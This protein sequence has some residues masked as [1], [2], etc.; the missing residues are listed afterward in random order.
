MI[1]L[2]VVVGALFDAYAGL[3]RGI[4]R[5]KRA[6]GYGEQWRVSSQRLDGLLCG[7]AW[8]VVR[9][10]SVARI[11]W[12]FPS[13][14]VHVS[15]R[16][17][18]GEGEIVSGVAVPPVSVWCGLEWPIAHKL[19]DAIGDRELSVSVHHGALWWNLGMNPH[20]SSSSDPK[21]Q[22]GCFD[23]ADFLFGKP[24]VTRELLTEERVPLAFPEGVYE[25]TV[26]LFDATV[27]RPRSPLVKRGRRASV[28]V[29]GGVPVPGKG[30]N[31]W[32]C[33]EDALHEQW[34]YS[35][36][37]AEAVGS[38]VEAVYESRLKYGGRDWKP[39]E[40]SAEAAA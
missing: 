24:Q 37:V 20:E 16:S 1:D 3:D 17:N 26:Q 25:A 18:R 8:L 29:V 34:T 7:R 28:A 33:D 27:K 19:V 5:A 15:V 11:E 2:W 9:D 38:F 13:S 4:E 12:A 32:D 39:K 10:E 30:E 21:W 14:S 35:S 22:R 36:S 6:V 40:K 31:S 23:F